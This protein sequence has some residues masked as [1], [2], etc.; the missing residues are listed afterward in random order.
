MDETLMKLRILAKAEATLLKANARRAA[1][2]A[3]LFAIAIGLILL[4]VIMLNVAAYQYLLESMSAFQAALLVGAAN[5][6]LA[7]IAILLAARVQPGQEEAMVRDIREMALSELSGDVDLAKEEFVRLSGDLNRIRS[8]VSSALGL[9][10]SGV[11]GVGS[12]SPALGI[13]TKM[14]KR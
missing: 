8:N 12:V 6:V 10:K 2:R 4:T 11:P 13:I 14:L 1:L 5:A 7:V 9:F 3:R